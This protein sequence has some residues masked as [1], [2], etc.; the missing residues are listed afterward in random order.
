M[1]ETSW[2]HDMVSADAD[3]T[4]H[5]VRLAKGLAAHNIREL[6]DGFQLGENDVICG[7]GRKCFQHTGNQKFRKLVAD[8]LPKYH[9]SPSK[10]TK[11]FI[12]CDIVNQVL[13]S[14]ATGGFVKKDPVTG[15]FFEVGDF[16][17]V[18]E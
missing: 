2:Q 6:T 9:E 12:I 3:E 16:L 7:R 17:A 5:T 10:L 13:E 18:S 14:S 15:K 8:L 11:S 4:K 1:D